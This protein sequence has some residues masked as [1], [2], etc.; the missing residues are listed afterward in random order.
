MLIAFNSEQIRELCTVDSNAISQLGQKA[1]E[2]LK[3]RLA[4][5][6]AAEFI[7]EVL[8]GRPRRAVV[9]G[10][11]CYLL[12]L[13]DGLILTLVCNQVNPKLDDQGQ[14]DWSRVRRVKVVSVGAT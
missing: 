8:A 10:R 7:D 9:D 14:I 12:D 13:V 3:N 11:D 5:I 4:D 1:A 2:T 6:D